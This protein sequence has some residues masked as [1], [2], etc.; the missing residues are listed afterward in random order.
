MTAPYLGA[1]AA[2]QVLSGRI[3]RGQVET[4]RATIWYGD[5]EGFT[6]LAD[7][8]PKERLLA[9]LNDMALLNDYAGLVLD[10]VAAKGWQMLELSGDGVLAIFDL[11]AAGTACRR[12]LGAAVA[13]ENAAAELGARL[14]RRGL[15]PPALRAGP[16]SATRPATAPGR[17]RPGGGKTCRSSTPPVSA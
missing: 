15:S 12:A 11:D 10:T 2:A 6:R 14:R 7:A 13:V 4:I 1:H 5:L 3:A 17:G 8:R 16:R 9:L